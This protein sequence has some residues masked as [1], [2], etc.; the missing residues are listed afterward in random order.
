MFYKKN[1]VLEGIQGVQGMSFDDDTV[2]EGQEFAIWAD[3]RT[4]PPPWIPP[5]VIVT[6]Q[7]M[8]REQAEALNFYRANKVPPPPRHLGVITTKNFE[9]TDEG[10]KVQFMQPPIR[11][12]APA[13][14][15]DDD[16]EAKA[17][18]EKAEKEENERRA[19][20]T[21]QDRVDAE[22]KE[23]QK[24]AG[25]PIDSIAIESLIE[26]L[27]GV[28]EKNASAVIKRFATLEELSKA[29]NADLRTCNIKSN[30]FK[31]VRSSAVELIAALEQEEE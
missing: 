26:Y 11:H 25:T 23:K 27:K 12:E 21:E 8:S 31:L 28:T 29:S 1:P 10:A 17:A 15:I 18:A 24:A 2:V 9:N 13:P 30:F 20:Q 16:A 14:R 5:L 22:D 3:R 7:E 19:A 4:F 6:A